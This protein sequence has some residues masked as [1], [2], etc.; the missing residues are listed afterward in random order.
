MK[1]NTPKKKVAPKKK[2]ITDDRLEGAFEAI[3]TGKFTVAKFVKDYQLTEAQNA[4][5]VEFTKT[6]D[7]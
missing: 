4:L 5:F 3:R 2:P 7:K 1:T 6:L